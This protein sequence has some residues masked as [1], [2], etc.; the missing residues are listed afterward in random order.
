M[1]VIA[2]AVLLSMISIVSSTRRA[3]G[4]DDT[5]QYYISKS[6]LIVAGTITSEPYGVSSEAGVVGYAFTFKISEVLHGRLPQPQTI[7]TGISRFEWGPADRL[8]FMHSGADC[9]L[10]LRETKEWG[11]VGADP[12]FG[13]QPMSRAMARS[14]QRLSAAAANPNT[15]SQPTPKQG[16]A[17]R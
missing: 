12:W 7:S 3:D 15:A 16:A 11:E 17:E 13:I 5:L 10:F 6:D 2:A 1:N 9:I 4:A 8:P 14:I